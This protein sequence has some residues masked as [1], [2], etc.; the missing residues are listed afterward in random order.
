MSG[1]LIL[2]TTAGLA[3]A[4]PAFTGLAA[5]RDGSR[6]WFSSPLRLQGEDTVAHPKIYVWDARPAAAT[7]LEGFRLL[8]QREAKLSF[9]PG[10]VLSSTFHKLVGVSVSGDASVVAVNATVECLNFTMCAL[11][12]DRAQTAIARP[13]AAV[14]T[15]PEFA[16]LSPNGRFALLTQSG[17]GKRRLL[18]LTTGTA[19][20]PFD[21]K[22]VF[23]RA[24][25]N[26]GTVVQGGELRHPGAAVTSLPMENCGAIN[27]A[28]TRVFCID[29][30]RAVAL[31][32]ASG[33]VNTVFTAQGQTAVR[34]D[35]SES[36][37]EVLFADAAGLWFVRSDGTALRRLLDETAVAADFVISGNGTTA[38][39]STADSR[40]LRLDLANRSAA[41]LAPATPAVLLPRV[42]GVMAQGSVYRYQYPASPLVREVRLPG[43]A[44]AHVVAAMRDA[45]YFQVPYDAP[46][47]TGSPELV[48][49]TQPASPFV[50]SILPGPVGIESFAPFWYTQ[51]EPGSTAVP[52]AA[53][54]QDFRGPVTAEDPA[55]A[56]EIVHVFGGGF[57]AVE[58]QPRL[59]EAAPATPLARVK[60]ADLVCSV[61]S[62]TAEVLFAGL[63]P[64]WVGLYQFD[65]RLPDGI[66]TSRE[67]LRCGKRDSTSAVGLLPVRAQ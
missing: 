52:M 49:A 29:G 1:L 63:A 30:R 31:E 47:A 15:E 46:A 43:G 28:A 16:Q 58:P 35:I 40:L 33:R 44:R 36:G 32:L 67:F 22:R 57:G 17:P 48:L 26:D 34:F 27:A 19:G 60:M 20:A 42:F 50:A 24:V 64:G 65:V 7:P 18:D 3:V 55:V 5:N 38:F 10:G 11:S 54:H 23:A 59:G 61:G 6:L 45:T 39:V 2:V 56:G 51:G 4:Q 53:L 12:S 14:R 25:A 66:G 21:P 62:R 9:P 8:E 41:E 37:D 13:G